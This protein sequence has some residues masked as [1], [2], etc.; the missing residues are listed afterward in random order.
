M[1]VWEW[2]VYKEPERY[3]LPDKPNVYF[4]LCEIYK[5]RSLDLR[6]D[7]LDD[8]RDYQEGVQNIMIGSLPRIGDMDVQA[9]IQPNIVEFGG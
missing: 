9:L 8:K 6:I 4:K 7:T 1:P 2:S 3:Q 5:G